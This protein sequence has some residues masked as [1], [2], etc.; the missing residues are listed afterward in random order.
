MNNS[1]MW[2]SHLI[3]KVLFQIGMKTMMKSVKQ[4]EMIGMELN[5]RERNKLMSS[6]MRVKEALSSLREGL[7]A[8]VHLALNQV[9][10]SKEHLVTATF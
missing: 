2:N 1:M 10:Y 5:G 9:T 4:L 3:S 6:M 8:K 7:M